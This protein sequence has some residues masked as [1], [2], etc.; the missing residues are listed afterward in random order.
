MISVRVTTGHFVLYLVAADIFFWGSQDRGYYI[1]PEPLLV[2]AAKV[3]QRT[4]LVGQ[5][6]LVSVGR[7]E[8]AI[9][10]WHCA[11]SPTGY[12]LCIQFWWYCSKNASNYID[13]PRTS[14][15]SGVKQ[16]GSKSASVI[17]QYKGIPEWKSGQLFHERTLV[18]TSA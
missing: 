12:I 3:F 15:F 4:V 17:W 5:Y 13:R 7:M 11:R 10:L 14:V 18:K 2:P 8:A 1:V 6:C 9:E 16:S